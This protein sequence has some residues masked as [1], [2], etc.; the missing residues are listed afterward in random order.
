M[1]RRLAEAT[2]AWRAR[3][4]RGETVLRRFRWLPLFALVLEAVLFA[5]FAELFAVFLAEA[6]AGVLTAV[7]P[8]RGGAGVGAVSGAAV[9]AD[10][11]F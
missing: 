6:F 4:T 10:G 7:L 5:V 9:G 1:G 11:A 2:N 8:L 3:R